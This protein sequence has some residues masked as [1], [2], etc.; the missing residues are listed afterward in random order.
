MVEATYLQRLADYFAVIGTGT[1]IKTTS[2][3]SE[4]KSYFFLWFR[5]QTD[6][7]LGSHHNGEIRNER[8]AAANQHSNAACCEFLRPDRRQGTEAAPEKRN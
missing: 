7:K 2:I 4:R 5:V 8:V 3:S 6:F 1:D